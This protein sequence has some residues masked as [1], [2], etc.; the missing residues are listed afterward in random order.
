MTDPI[1]ILTPSAFEAIAP[2][3]PW[4]FSGFRRLLDAV[5]GKCAAQ[6][7]ELGDQI[8]CKP[9]CHHCCRRIPTILPIEWAWIRETAKAHDGSIG[10]DLRSDLHPG[11]AL[12]GHLDAQGLCRIYSA[13]PLICRTHGLLILSDDGLDHCPWNFQDLEEVD[14]GLPFRLENLHETLLRLNLAFLQAAHPSRWRELTGIRVAF[15]C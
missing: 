14:E 1:Q 5:D 2:E 12:C 3:A 4:D 8:A 11:E 15:Q 7:R 6:E 10:T 9:G 13:R